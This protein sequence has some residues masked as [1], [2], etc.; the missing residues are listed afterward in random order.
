MSDQ[1]ILVAGAGGFIGGHL[2]GYLR[3]Q[4]HTRIR[5]VDLKPLEEW[6]QVFDDVE[7]HTADLKDFS[8]C[9]AACEDADEVYNLA[10]DMGG[11]GFI[12]NNKALCM[13][14]VLVNTHML[15]AAR[16]AGVERYFFSSSACVYNADKQ[17]DPNVTALKEEA[18]SRATQP[19]ATPEPTSADPELGRRRHGRHVA[20]FKIR[21]RSLA[22]LHEMYT[23]D[24]SRGGM[25]IVTD[26]LIPVGESIHVDVVHPDTHERFVLSCVVRRAISDPGR[27]GLGVEFIDMDEERYYRPAYFGDG[28]IGIR[29]DLGDNDWDAIANWLR[30]SWRSIAPKKLTGLID[31][32]DEF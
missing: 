8:L 30:R 13:L 16:Q 3:R 26:Q 19:S 31:V 23:R 21:P 20:T 28:W 18:R 11:M 4:G 29:L 27:T 24:I 7:N 25:F 14:S 1:Q 5:A 32:A 17:R 15:M 9:R 12:E 22:R 10:A 2:V 6:F